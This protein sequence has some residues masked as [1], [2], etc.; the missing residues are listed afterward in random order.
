MIF[1]SCFSSDIKKSIQFFHIAFSNQEILLTT[2]LRSK[3]LFKMGMRVLRDPGEDDYYDGRTNL[4]DQ[5]YCGT[6]L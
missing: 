1:E 2:E 4:L 5:I 3:R 6:V